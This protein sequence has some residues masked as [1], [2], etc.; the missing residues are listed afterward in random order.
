MNFMPPFR[1]AVRRTSHA[2]PAAV[3]GV[4]AN[5]V[6]LT[7]RS[8]KGTSHWLIL[9]SS[10]SWQVRT[11]SF[12]FHMSIAARASNTQKLAWLAPEIAWWISPASCS[13]TLLAAQVVVQWFSRQVVHRLLHFPPQPVKTWQHK[14]SAL[15][16]RAGRMA[17]ACSAHVLSEGIQT[18]K[19]SQ[20]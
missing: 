16:A 15:A 17:S 13:E 12:V 20:V 19:M 18:S 3:H 1:V 10:S 11:G 5:C 2:S 14:R 6:S 7:G 9:D 8:P 4:C